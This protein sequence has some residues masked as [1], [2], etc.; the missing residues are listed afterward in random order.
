[1]RMA[2]HMQRMT[3]AIKALILDGSEGG[4]RVEIGHIRMK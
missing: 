4:T 2:R 1:M 3:T